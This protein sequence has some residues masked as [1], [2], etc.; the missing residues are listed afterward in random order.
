VVGD[1]T[2][3]Y[4]AVLEDLLSRAG[5]L[6]QTLTTQRLHGQIAGPGG[7]LGHGGTQATA[8]V[9]FDHQGR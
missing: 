5:R 8:V 7:D 2:R 9:V 6:G 4:A 3:A 1:L